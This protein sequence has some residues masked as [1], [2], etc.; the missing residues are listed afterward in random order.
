MRDLSTNTKI[1]LVLLGLVVVVV[2]F[3]TTACVPV[4]VQAIYDAKAE[5]E[6]AKADT[7]R[8]QA[9]AEWARTAQAQAEAAEAIR[10]AP[11]RAQAETIA[12][13]LLLLVGVGVSAG[14][15]AALVVWSIMRARLVFA[16]KFGLYPVIVGTAPAT[17]LNEPGAQH[18]RIAP[19]R[20]PYQ[21]LPPEPD[22]IPVIPQVIELDTQRLQ[23]IERLLLEPPAGVDYDN[24]D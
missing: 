10:Q 11:A 18:A 2:L 21:I 15:G 4:D 16:D 7:A 24:T 14:C 23:H 17:N 3:I 13:G 9:A 5:N 6:H 20:A 22:A 8:A 19:G 12:F 1:G